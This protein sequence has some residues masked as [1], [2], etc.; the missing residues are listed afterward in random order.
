[1]HLYNLNCVQL[2]QLDRWAVIPNKRV[3]FCFLRPIVIDLSI[4]LIRSSSN[5]SGSS[6]NIGSSTSS[7][8]SNYN[9]CDDNNKNNKKY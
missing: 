5:C 8:S 3:I 2:K 9:K 6:G 7:V 4:K 1:M